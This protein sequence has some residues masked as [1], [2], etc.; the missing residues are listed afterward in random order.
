M[1]SI[2]IGMPV[3]N[4]DRYIERS[5]RSAVNQCDKLVISDNASTDRTLDICKSIACEYDKIEIIQQDRNIGSQAN[6]KFLLDKCTTEYFMWLGGHDVI[7]SNYVDS[8]TT[9]LDKNPDAV[10]AFGDSQHIDIDGDASGVYRYLF[11][12]KLTSDVPHTRLMALLRYLSDATMFYGIWRTQILRSVWIDEA[13]TGVDR[14]VLL[15]AA[16][17][18]KLVRAP[19][20]SFILRDAHPHDTFRTYMKRITGNT[21]LNDDSR[22]RMGVNHEEMC[23]RSFSLFVKNINVGVVKRTRLRLMAWFLLIVRYNPFSDRPLFYF[24]V[25]VSKA[26][27]ALRKVR[28]TVVSLKRY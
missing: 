8:L 25:I 16:A 14:F 6:F 19:N 11:G 18:G 1:G 9:S 22:V 26:G 15:H 28:R 5:I 27:K 12:D 17:V 2:T 21:E 20:T 3:F 13:F 23:R 7:P 4:E 24:E 10:L